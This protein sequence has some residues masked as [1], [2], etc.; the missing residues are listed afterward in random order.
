MPLRIYT[1]NRMEQLVE[2]LA[3]VLAEP[4]DSPFTPEVIVVQSKGMQRWLAMELAK[5]FGIWANCTYPFP[6][7]IVWDLFCKTLPNIPDVSLFSPEIL[8]WK[9][10]ALLP[11]CI[12]QKE[13]APLKHYLGGENAG[14]K[15]FQ[16][17]EKIADCFDQYTLF[18]PD[19]LLEWEQGRGGEWQGILWREVAATGNGQHRGKLKEE[20]CRQMTNGIRNFAVPERI[21]VFGISYLPHYHLET[22]KATAAAIDVN[23]FLLSPTREY[24]ADILPEREMIRLAP[25]ARAFR[26]EGNPLLASLGKLGRDFSDMVVEMTETDAAQEDLS[27]DP[28]CSSLLSAVQSDIL[29]LLGGDAGQDR[30]QIDADD[31]SIQ[32]HSCHSP[33]REIEILHDNLLS[34]L[35]YSDDLAPRDIVVMTPDIETYAPYIAT[36][37]EGGEDLCR[38]IPYSIADRN[39]TCNGDIAMVV[40]KLLGLPGSR[41][42][43]PQLLDILE[44]KPVRA[45]FDLDEH[46]L[47]IIRGWLEATR[48]R[49]GID[50]RDRERCGLP[51]Y[52]ENSWRAGLDR[53]LLGYAMPTEGGHLLNGILPFDEM[54]GSDT[55]TLGKLCEFVTRISTCSEMLARSRT[56]GEWRD[57]FRLLLGSFIVADEDSAHEFTAV[58]GVVEQLGELG[59]AAGFRGVIE[60]DVIRSWVSTRLAREE[61]GVGFMTGGVTFCAMLPMRSIPFRVVALIG[62]S[63]GAF[64]R[65]S[66]PPGFDLISRHPRRGDRSLRD[67]DR[68]LFLEAIL[69]AR[70]CFYISYIGQ[71]IKDNSEIPPSVLVSELI[72][73]VDKGFTAG[74][75]RAAA[76]RLVVQHRLQAFSSDY[77]NGRSMLFSYSSENCAALRERGG[78]LR[79]PVEFISRPIAPP[80]EEWRDVSLAKLLQFFDNPT[81]F[82]LENRLGIRLEDTAL[83]LEER[84]PFTV[85]GLDVYALKQEILETCLQGGDVSTYLPIARCR[86]IL[87]PAHHGAELFADVAKEVAEFA[88]KVRGVISG[89][90]TLSPLD[91]ELSLGTFRL[92]GRLERIWPDHMI[93]YRCAKMKA[94]DRMR[95]WFEHLF[96]TAARP[97]RYPEETLLVMADSTVTYG[98]VEDAA[99]ILQDILELYWEGLTVPLRFFP[100]S[101]MEYAKKLEWNL[102]RA[103]TKWE[104]G[105]AFAGEGAD[106]YYRLC[107]GCN[108]PFNADFERVTRT[109]LTPLLHHQR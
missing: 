50:E 55:Q 84:E 21:A 64:P 18:R 74:D 72:D 62:M 102:E 105:Y 32:I 48:V 101:S 44:M 12:H 97:K 99:A 89:A 33:L 70:E 56:L 68:Y 78:G 59:E 53:L 100:A 24:W 57:E 85:D 90:P 31:R 4:L 8:T 43:V 11:E 41:C 69:S 46:D 45:C 40:L 13:F 82:L 104:D 23:L 76:S 35:E 17:A 20:Y 10:M 52:R 83:P 75:G 25:E 37:F 61:K 34:L 27:G 92:S 66:R 3:V 51:A 94:K 30:R 65:Q 79:E 58:S 109:L 9:I 91:V 38:K 6:N 42:S 98:A 81:R 14:L 2:A 47:E 108:D 63:D 103:R 106:P 67:E 29:N 7:K 19:M 93:R 95:A 26:I 28:G 15:L 88:T 22:L 73:A 80:S 54:E 96:L 1:S 77:F 36:V 71:S 107:F 87:P 49:W 86:G 60:L 39:I 5:K 16:L